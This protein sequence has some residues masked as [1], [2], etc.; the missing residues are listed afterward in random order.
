MP[1]QIVS[2]DRCRALVS[3][4]WANQ[5]VTG[6]AFELMNFIIRK[7]LSLGRFTVADATYLRS[8]DRLELIGVARG[9]SFRVAAIVF[10]VTLKT[11]LR[12][13]SERSRTVPEEALRLQHI[14]LRETL[15][16]IE[17]EGFDEVHVLDER[18][19]STVTVRIR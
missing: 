19:Q 12:R 3:D 11:C 15:G 2:S 1:T 13:N 7:R 10:D 17:G 14:L 18:D 6:D 9:L 5:Q 4:D 16:T 8:L